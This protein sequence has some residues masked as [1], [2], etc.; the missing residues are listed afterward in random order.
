MA[1]D[2]KNIEIPIRHSNKLCTNTAVLLHMVGGCMV[3][4][5]VGGQVGCCMYLC[6]TAVV[7]LYVG[8]AGE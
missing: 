2:H 1:G 4:G 3:G 6:C 7:L 8:G 5:C